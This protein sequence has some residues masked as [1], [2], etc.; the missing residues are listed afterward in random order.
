MWFPRLILFH[1]TLL[2]GSSGKV[3][4]WMQQS[5]GCCFS[6]TSAADVLLSALWRSHSP[7]QRAMGYFSSTG[8]QASPNALYDLWASFGVYWMC[9]AHMNSEDCIPCLRLRVP[10]GGGASMMWWLRAIDGSWV[11]TKW[12]PQ[13]KDGT[14]SPRQLSHR[15]WWR[16]GIL[17]C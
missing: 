3:E 11:I 10:G 15:G 2:A 4:K 7:I 12:D 8:S 6:E 1:W 9:I 17:N 16:S 5:S 13:E 14:E